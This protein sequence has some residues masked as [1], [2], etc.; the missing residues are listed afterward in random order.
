MRWRF[1]GTVAT[2]S[3]AVLALLALIIGSYYFAIRPDQLRWG[4]TPEELARPLPGDHLVAPTSLCA[5][6]AVTIAG[7]PEDIWPW[8]LQIGYDRAGFYGYDLIENLGSKRGIRSAANI[9][10][11]LQRLSVGD[12]VYMSR[13]AYLVIYSMTPYRFLI[14]ADADDPPHG[15]FTFGLFPL[16]A[17]HTRLVIRARLRYHW[18]DTRILLDLFTEFGDHVAVPRMLLG[19]R[20]RVEGHPVQPLAVESME[21]TVWMAALLEFLVAI[22]LIPVRREWWRDWI[23]ALLASSALLFA[24]YA[25]EPLWAGALLQIPILVSMVWAWGANRKE[26]E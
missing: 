17:N 8:I 15:A 11:D 4:A 5:T 10:P 24:L 21:I 26:S 14:W 20:D 2:K 19:I 22:A 12:R 9:V 7:R 23:T 6:R 1:S 13:I 18:T 16:D 3:L 25:R